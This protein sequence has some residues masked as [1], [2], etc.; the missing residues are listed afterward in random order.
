MALRLHGNGL[1]FEDAERNVRVKASC[2]GRKVSKPRLCQRRGDFRPAA[3]HQG[4]WEWDHPQATE[5]GTAMAKNTKKAV[6]KNTKPSPELAGEDLRRVFSEHQVV[7]ER[8]ETLLDTQDVLK[9][10]RADYAEAFDRL[11]KQIGRA[12]CRERG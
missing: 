1:V 6:R 9:Q 4:I 8:A 2:G 12:S 5:K 10:A 3:G 7:E 11:D